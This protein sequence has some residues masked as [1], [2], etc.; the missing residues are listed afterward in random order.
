MTANPGSSPV[1]IRQAQKEDVETVL[2]LIDAL[3]DY[4]SLPRP[5]ADARARLAEHGFGPRPRFEVFL[6]EL[7]GKAIGYTISF[8]TYS[9]FLARPTFYL[10]DLFVLPEYR[11]IRAGL[12]LFKNCV[13]LARQR[14][15]GRMEWQVLD[16][17]VNSI[18]FYEQLGAK[19]LQEWL[20]Y[21][22]TMDDL[23]T[24]DQ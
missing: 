11:K 10:E 8:E 14:E 20:P 15:C 17:N 18:R 3:A 6:A 13:R 16:W 1:T 21:R 5:E 4:E 22:L 7:D 19:R 9:S 24:L 23:A 12:A 2:N